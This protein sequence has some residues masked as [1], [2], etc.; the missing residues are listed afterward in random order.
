MTDLN[1]KATGAQTNIEATGALNNAKASGLHNK[2][3]TGIL[4]MVA[5]SICFSTGGLL[6]KLIPWNPLAINGA[7]TLIAGLVIGL[8]LIITKHPLKFN[9]IVFVGALCM[10]GVTT[11]FTIANK[12]TTAGHAILLQYTAPIWI[13]ILLAVL[14]GIRPGKVEIITIVT[15]LI[16]IAC[17]F[18]DSLSAGGLMGDLFALLAG[19]CYAGVFMLNQFEEGDALSSMFFGQLACGL[20]FS[21]MVMRET[22][23]DARIWGCII[24]LGTVQVGLAYILFSIGTKYT[25]PVTS[26]VINAMEPILNPVLVAVIYGEHLGKPALIGAVIVLCGILFYQSQERTRA[27]S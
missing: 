25:D 16:G 20:V 24:L 15:V 5:A 2:R 18:V 8:Y 23:F 14:F 9:R 22:V 3:R 19:I 21:P 11:F 1:T 10:A 13:I 12:L 27:G 6:I 17:F 4:A 26:S 7:R